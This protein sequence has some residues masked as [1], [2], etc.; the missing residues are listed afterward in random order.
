MPDSHEGGRA[1]PESIRV[2]REI[3]E[4]RFP[5]LPLTLLSIA[6]PTRSVLIRPSISP[7]RS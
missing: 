4:I 2:I 7:I 6:A 1:F 5:V 3:R